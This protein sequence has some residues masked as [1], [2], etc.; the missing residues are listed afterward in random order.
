ME[1]LKEIVAATITAIATI[2]AAAI[3]YRALRSGKN[4]FSPNDTSS[5]DEN[6]E[7]SDARWIENRRH[8]QAPLDDDLTAIHT[9]IRYKSPA[10]S[11]VRLLG[12]SD[13][14]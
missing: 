7:A 3:G 12:E 5:N 10:T 1:Y 14:S 11:K 2:I 13:E 9:E 6:L 8:S 4:K